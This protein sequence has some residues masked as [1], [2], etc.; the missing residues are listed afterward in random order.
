MTITERIDAITGLVPEVCCE[1]PPAPRSVKIELTGR[2]NYACSFCAL[3]TREKQP[4]LDMDFGLFTR[5]TRQMREAGVEEI[6]IFYLGE[7]L[8][9]PVLAVAAVDYLKRDL[10]MPYVFLTSNGSLATEPIVR[11][12]MR[13]GLD[14]LKWSVNACDVAQFENLMGV[15]PKLFERA[16]HNI[17]GA[18][19]VRERGGFKTGLYASSIQYDDEQR[20]K[21]EALLDARVRP[22]VDEHYFLPLYTMG[23]FSEQFKAKLGYTPF[24]GNVGRL[25]RLRDPLPCWSAFSEG[26][27]R[28]DGHLSV[29]C[30]GADERF[31]AGDLTRQTFME[32]WHSETFRAIRRAQLRAAEEGFDAL[33]GT[34]CEA[35]VGWGGV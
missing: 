16:L 22:F 28:S 3:R 24:A 35:C 33:K 14:S 8:T 21:M 25:D 23:M 4:A 19:G 7:T 10:G 31:D 13:A 29:C 5:M 34:M 12:L 20:V 30:F 18:W 27:V 15:K 32:A 17:K 6:G 11:G 26:H 1:A 9:N 2:C